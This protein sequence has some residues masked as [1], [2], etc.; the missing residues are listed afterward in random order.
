MLRTFSK[1][2][3]IAGARVGY[4]VA[5]QGLIDR[6][7]RIKLPYNLNSLSR[8]VAEVVLANYGIVEDRVETIL[9]ERKRMVSEFADYC[10]PTQT[11]FVLMDIDAK[12]FL[13]SRGIGVRGFEGRLGDKI[14]VT[15]GKKEE[16][17]RLIDELRGYLEDEN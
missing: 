8:T 3:G 9:A 4:A 11:N 15:V 2:F 7:L 12:E 6:L 10:Y 17:D 5:N 1:A 16:N 14:R 13:A